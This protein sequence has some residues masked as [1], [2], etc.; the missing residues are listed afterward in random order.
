MRH[1]SRLAQVL[2]GLAVRHVSE[3]LS[4]ERDCRLIFPGLTK[5]LAIELHEQL[6]DRLS[7]R[8]REGRSR[9]PTYLA[10]DYPDSE[11]MP[12][13]SRGW[14]H[15]EAV[16]SVRQGSFVT[17][18][19]PKVFP[20]LHDS[21]RGSGSP[22]RGLTFADDW[23][24]QDSGAAAFRFTGPVLDDILDTW[25][26][27]SVSR[28]WIRSLIIDGLLPATR[29]LRDAVRVP[30]LL[31]DVLGSFDPRVYASIDSVVDKFCF[32]CGIPKIANYN[33]TSPADHIDAVGRTARALEELRNRN[34]AFRD[35]LVNEVAEHVFASY[36]TFKLEQ[37]KQSLDLLLDGALE[38]GAS[39]GVLA[40]RGGLGN[41]SSSSSVEA[42][43]QL[44]ID[45][46]K[47]LLG[48][49]EQ[50]KIQC[51][52]L[53]LDEDGVISS[54]GKNVAIIEGSTVSLDV[55][56]RIERDRFAA[57]G[58][59]IRCKRRQKEI[60]SQE[61]DE[62]EFHITIDIPPCELRSSSTRHSLA[63]QLTRFQQVVQEA[64]VLVYV[65]G[66]ERPAVAVVEPEFEVIDMLEGESSLSDSESLVLRCREPVRVHVLDTLG[67]GPYLVT[68][69]D[70]SLPLIP[71]SPCR[72][73]SGSTVFRL[74]DSV[75]VESYAGAR[76]D[77]RIETS[78]HW[79]SLTLAGD[80]IEPGEFTLEDEFR[81]AIATT[82][83]S[84]LRRV[85]PFFSGVEDRILPKLGEI[86]APARRRMELG[87][88]FEKADGWKPILVDFVG[89]PRSA[90]DVLDSYRFWR[91]AGSGPTFLE[92]IVPTDAFD[93]ALTQ[94]TSCRDALIRSTRSYV[95][96][97]ITPSDRPLYV[98]A[99]NYVKRD[100]SSI[101]AKI[102]QYLEAYIA[103]L[104]LLRDGNL[105]SSEVCTL[106]HLDSIVL[107]SNQSIDK[108]L[109]LRVS[110]LGPW[111]PLVVAKRFMVQHWMYAA[112]EGGKQAA[113][114]FGR[115][116][117]LFKQVDAFRVVL[118]FD[119]NSLD[120]DVG[121][122]FPTS[123]PGWHLCLSSRSLDA[124]AR[125]AFGNAREFGQALR[126]SLGLSS[127]FNLA[128]ADVWRES[129]IYS[130]HRSHPSRRQLG[131]RVSQGL[132]ARPMIGACARLLVDR[133]NHSLGLGELLPGGIHLFLE[134]RLEQREQ[135]SWQQPSA[136]VYEALDDATCYN[137]FH[138]D[139]LLHSQREDVSLA[140]LQSDQEGLAVPRGSGRGAVFFMPLVDLARDG[141]GRP[142][143]RV[144]ESDHA[145]IAEQ[146]LAV[147]LQNGGLPTVGEGFRRA[148]AGIGALTGRFQQ[149][150][151]AIRQ[152]LALP[153]SLK[154]DWSVLPGAQ[155]D[156][157]ALA[158][159]ITDRS[160]EAATEQ[161]QRALWDYRL[162]VG[163]SVRSYFIVCRVPKS[164]LT[165]LAASSL[166]LST[167]GASSAL[168]DLAAVGFAVGETMRSGKAAVGVLG[169]VG[170]LRL[171]RAAWSTGEAKGLR[172]CTILLPVDCITSL[173]VASHELE[174]S[175]QRSDLLAINLAWR[176]DG[177]LNL[178][179]APCA[180]ECKYV[181][182]VYQHSKVEGSLGQAK[183]TYQVVSR[184][185]SLA[186]TE[187]GMHARLALCHIL[188]FGLRLLVARNEATMTDEQVILDAVLSGSFYFEEPIA[189][190]LLVT[191]S[192]GAKGEGTVEVRNN[193]WWVQL[194]RD[195]WPREIPT[196]T[197]PLIEQL[198]RVFPAIELCT[199]DCAHIGKG[200]EGSPND[201]SEYHG[202][203]AQGERATGYESGAS[204]TYDLSDEEATGKSRRYGLQAMQRNAD[205]ESSNGGTVDVISDI[206]VHEVFKGFV[207]N[208]AAVA[209]LSI[210][211]HYVE[212]TGGTSIRSV[213]LFG[214][215]STGKTELSRRLASAL[216][217]PYLPLSE[218]S[219]RDIDQLAERMQ[220]LARETG[221]PMRVI[222]Q[223]G[224]QAVLR[225]P[226]MLVFIDEVHQLS[227]R[228]QD[229]LL[230]VLEADDRMLRGSS[231]TIDAHDVS[232]II[233]TTDW[234]KLREAFL[235]RVR[236]VPLEPYTT[237]EVV[238]MLRYRIESASLEHG[239]E[240]DI[241]PAVGTLEDDALNA[242]ATAARA[243]PRVALDL[244]REIGMAL[245][246]G[247]HGSNVDAIWEH[248]QRM[249]PCDRRGL[250]SLDRKY[251]RIVAN[252]GP[253]GLDNIA[254][255]LGTDRSNIERAVEP[256]LAQMGWLQ[257][258]PMGRTLTSEGRR[259]LSRY[260]L[261]EE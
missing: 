60:F 131:I 5:E 175:S 2:S 88:E 50:E 137:H 208:K 181:T 172:W 49:G 196:S 73:E 52:I 209:T 206:F 182:G 160:F 3:V 198:S 74:R 151:L 219:L 227:A 113:K 152:D 70:E 118:A 135:L 77:L 111:H 83:S 126:S 104:D 189:S 127:W 109:D 256:F 125:S 61:C 29:P 92:N 231:V 169:V 222:D 242:I 11:L 197:N 122:A 120:L 247:I 192:C 210:Q 156:A 245:R 142:V 191:T 252:R 224:G 153:S 186:L 154:C 243:V 90:Q 107:G 85:L 82:H 261:T 168:R 19:M 237:E 174:G 123:D 57:G 215:K 28:H 86:D 217:V 258:G 22:I 159:H 68:A 221:T 25:T 246:I 144:R 232:F 98:V 171:A 179:I 64:R 223:Q 236:A 218:T 94:Y 238:Q 55:R 44:D 132:D 162:D 100:E 62:A 102:S 39:S 250:R 21:I 101:E 128:G 45:I 216:D 146:S 170:A 35:Y 180:V 229:T 108:S 205:E 114:Q 187:T 138:P 103:I 202:R 66:T 190:T 161:E 233:A 241:D 249:V 110:L 260:S 89:G 167:L 220:K 176:L 56:G 230:P 253:I 53:L 257:R 226:P 34:P 65:C 97:Y 248:L 163:Q 184:L 239:T 195:C 129:L 203:H 139:I 124:L 204:S 8:C 81:V 133:A 147:S 79:R 54:D 78:S 10:L 141:D 251:M 36:D 26:S 213:G 121:L 17:V 177:P 143:S 12:E 149:N 185:L 211:L 165:S 240:N 38:L 148:L 33:E 76:V 67:V 9:V 116:V 72:G 16:T 166:D 6:R 173:L 27:D 41:K 47:K 255:E 99:P 140:W 13:E 4:D 228:V 63:V 164:V 178:T 207:G 234:G 40:Y 93:A 87:R 42:W 105:S 244:L 183:A 69:D 134:D 51:S 24:W 48:V 158:T 145:R 31:E 71:E 30:L 200:E 95:Q 32:H 259:L 194:T 225:S 7:S 193:G 130:Y 37:L 23:P 112:T 58:Y 214:P 117:S 91:M 75:D 188:R 18:C 14:L 155:I 212:E 150:R 20:K 115:L 201:H 106:V 157:G 43:S 254:T 59:L 199:E 46:L 80:D 235:S 119:A 84:R 136:V 1:G 15:Y 96:E